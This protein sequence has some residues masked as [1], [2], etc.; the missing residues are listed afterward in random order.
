MLGF[1]LLL[2]IAVKSGKR[3]DAILYK[4][5]LSNVDYGVIL[6]R[7]EGVA[8]IF[9]S[10]KEGARLLFDGYRYNF[11]LAFVD[12]SGQKLEFP[13]MS[14]RDVA[15]PDDTDWVVLGRYGKFI[16]DIPLEDMNDNKITDRIPT[17]GSLELK[18]S[19]RTFPLMV[20]DPF[21]KDCKALQADAVTTWRL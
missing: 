14:V 1:F 2:L 5:S 10:S 6:S 3:N 13:D 17:T 11:R 16:I 18:I 9:I 20:Q 19:Q 15:G 4:H 7:N 12:A 21:L 8:H